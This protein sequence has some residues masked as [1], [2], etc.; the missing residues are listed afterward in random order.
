[1]PP[2]PRSFRCR[3]SAHPG[4]SPS[5]DLS[6]GNTA[7]RTARKVCLYDIDNHLTGEFSPEN[8]GVTREEVAER[9][10][11]T[12]GELLIES[13][14]LKAPPSG[15]SAGEKQRVAIGSL[16]VMKTP[17]VV[18]DEPTLPTNY[19]VFVRALRSAKVPGTLA[20]S[21]G[22]AFRTMSVLSEDTRGIMD[23][24]RSRGM[25]FDRDLLT[26]NRN[27]LTAVTVPMAVTVLRR[28]RNLTAAMESRGFS[29]SSKPSV[30]RNPTFS[31][32]DFF[33]VLAVIA[34]VGLSW[35]AYQGSWL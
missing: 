8:K 19:T 12:A 11:K 30:Y 24:Q 29:S 27:K 20:F 33:T 2:A 31:R 22:T 18:L 7:V 16:L 6:K 15:L 9:I 13:L 21:L 5:H 10:Q 4:G 32:S 14:G 35:L 28:S 17:V 26:R 1:L 34:V 25:E 23:A 3:G